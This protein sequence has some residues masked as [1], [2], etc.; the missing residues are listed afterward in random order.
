MILGPPAA[1]RANTGSPSL[2]STIVGLMLER[3][4]FPAAI[5]L[6]SAPTRPNALGTPG[7]LEKSSISLFNTTPVP[8]TITFDPKEV[9]TVAVIA[10]Q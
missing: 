8:G 5:A 10:T 1:P 6:F 7:W 9:F 2:S 4:R 3:G